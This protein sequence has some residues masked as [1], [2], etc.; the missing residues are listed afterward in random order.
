MFGPLAAVS[1]A[2]RHPKEVVL[3]HDS[4]LSAEMDPRK[5]HD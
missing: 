3:R 1:V 2:V 5:W 4:I